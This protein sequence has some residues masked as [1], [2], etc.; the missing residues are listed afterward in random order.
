MRLA[1]CRTIGIARAVC[2]CVV[3]GR[4]R[5]RR[6]GVLVESPQASPLPRLPPSGRRALPSVGHLGPSGRSL[7]R[8]RRRHRRSTTSP[9]APG[10]SP[11]PL[12]AMHV[13]GVQLPAPARRRLVPVARSIRGG[14]QCRVDGIE[15]RCSWRCS[16]AQGLIRASART[17]GVGRQTVYDRRN[18]DP[19]F[20]AAWDAALAPYR[21]GRPQDLDALKPDKI[22]VGSI[23]FRRDARG[24]SVAR[25]DGA[26]PRA[27]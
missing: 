26:R 18:R 13:R 24:P 3:C 11:R 27:H 21:A 4:V 19:E 20:A 12:P 5:S 22:T 1:P 16:R 17:I 7:R 23:G 15:L 25:P 10:P 9:A 6:D 8:S 14:A 2:V